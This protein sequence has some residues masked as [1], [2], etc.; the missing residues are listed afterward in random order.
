MRFAADENFDGRVLKGILARL[1]DADIIRIQDTVMYQS[2][3]PAL[4]AWLAGENRVLLTHDVQTIPGFVYD[5]VRAG[6]PVPGVIEVKMSVSI[7]QIVDELEVIIGA[8]QREDFQNIIRYVP[9]G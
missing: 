2:P 3:D 1:P 4:L 9:M 7:G 5:R 6:L 8:G